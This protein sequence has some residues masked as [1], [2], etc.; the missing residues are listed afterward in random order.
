MLNFKDL[1]QLEEAQAIHKQNLQIPEQK[2]GFMHP[3][4]IPSV[5]GLASL[6]GKRGKAQE[7]VLMQSK[8]LRM[9][10]HAYPRGFSNIQ[11]AKMNLAYHL[12]E[13]SEIQ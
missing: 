7:A 8:V 11:V 1:G 3:S 4:T 10:Q 6:L 9:S 12:N 13:A 2:S 5:H